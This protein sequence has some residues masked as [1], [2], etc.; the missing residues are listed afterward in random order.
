MDKR[1]L[2]SLLG[3]LMFR[4][5]NQDRLSCFKRKT[6]GAWVWDGFGDYRS[7]G[8]VVEIKEVRRK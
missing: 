8:C 5:G 3:E 1:F 2:V 7:S 4:V 6:P